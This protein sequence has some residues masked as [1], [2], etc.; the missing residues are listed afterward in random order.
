MTW[1]T[2]TSSRCVGRV[3]QSRVPFRGPR[4]CDSCGGPGELTP[5]V[6]YRRSYMVTPLSLVKCLVRRRRQNRRRLLVSALCYPGSL[7]QLE[8]VGCCEHGCDTT[9][10]GR[11]F[12]AH[13]F[14]CCCAAPDASAFHLYTV[15]MYDPDAPSPDSPIC[16]VRWSRRVLANR[17]MARGH[18]ES[19]RICKRQLHA[20]LVVGIC[21]AGTVRSDWTRR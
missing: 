3:G 20:S 12:Q 13:V 1:P 17:D 8:H 5:H 11:G 6:S 15:I 4:C 7:E 19:A 9:R 18:S 16:K 14:V 10:R 2:I 21:R